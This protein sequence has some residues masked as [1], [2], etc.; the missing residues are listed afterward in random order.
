MLEKILGPLARRWPWLRTAL[1]VQERFGEVRGNYLASAVAL[2]IFLAIFPLL[3]VAIAV[4]G[5]IT[6]NNDDIIQRI[7][8]NV[9]MNPDQARLFTDTLNRAAETKKAASIIG[10]V[11][12]L[13]TGLGVVAAIEYALDATWQITG[14]GFKDK[15]RGFLWGLGALIILGAS[16]ALTT[17]VDIVAN[18]VVLNALSAVAAVFIN[19]VFWM[20]TFNVLSFHRVHWRRYLPGSLLAAIGLEVIKQ[21]AGALPGVIAH[22]SALYG[23]LSVV[24]GLLT[25]MVLFSRLIVYASVLNVVKWEAAKGTVSVEVEA[26]R[27]PGQAPLEADRAGAV[28]DK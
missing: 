15:A 8:D 4:A 26:P 27:L 19:V 6:Q 22:S 24:F 20:W 1:D 23:S 28:E 12:L 5:L 3:L 25:A 18:G 7:I 13:W 9:G 2:N 11:G 14:R 16:I 17:T 21:I 10:L